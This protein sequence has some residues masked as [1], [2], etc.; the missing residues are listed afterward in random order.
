MKRG[1]LPAALVAMLTIPQL[2][3]SVAVADC[4]FQAEVKLIITPENH[5]LQLD[6]W[7]DRDPSTPYQVGDNITVYARTNRDAYVYM[8]NISPTGEVVTL[9]P[10][11]REPSNFVKSGEV[12]RLPRGNYRITANT[13]GTEYLVAI[14]TLRPMNT[15]SYWVK[16]MLDWTD[17]RTPLISTAEELLK[18]LQWAELEPFHRGA[19][20]ATV[21]SFVVEEP[22]YWRLGHLSVSSNPS[23]A[24]V[25]VDG[26]HVG[27]TPCTV[28]DLVAGYHE[29]TLVKEGYRTIVD[30]VS[31]R[32]NAT[33]FRSYTFTP[34]A[35]Q[36]PVER[37]VFGPWRVLIRRENDGATR[38]FSADFGYSGAIQI[39][40]RETYDGKLYQIEGL[41]TVYPSGSVTQVFL[42]EADSIRESDRGRT[43]TNTV[44]P[45]KVLATIE[46]VELAQTG[47]VF[48]SKYIKSIALSIQVVWTG[49]TY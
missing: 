16:R 22:Y 24:M 40:P 35:I 10:S 2:F 42:L 20:A 44:G 4:S 12:L 6:L 1:F 32:A 19:Y 29:L 27:M 30:Q 5:D 21:I 48:S 33:E 14:A 28:R 13:P 43:I 45:F 37:V 15:Q 7:V 17:A 39:R 9:L 47:S 36:P 18:R 23:G 49:V 11:S 8:F 38:S 3:T 41:L 31:V 46:D 34:L 26:R 25:F